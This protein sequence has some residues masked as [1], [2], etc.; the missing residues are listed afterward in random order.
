[1]AAAAKPSPTPTKPPPAP[2]LTLTVTGPGLSEPLN[3]SRADDQQLYDKFAAQVSWMENSPPNVMPS[4][5]VELGPDY[6]IT[7]FS[8]GRKTV[9]YDLY[10][11]VP[12]GPRAHRSATANKQAAW[13]YG[14]INMAASLELLGVSIPTATTTAGIATPPPVASSAPPES[15]GQ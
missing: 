8:T 9:V 5:P 14:P 1:T 13:Y 4:A 6:T 15:F 3:V 12:G 2:K 10:P 7:L 11:L